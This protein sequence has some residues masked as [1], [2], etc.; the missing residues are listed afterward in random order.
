MAHKYYAVRIGRKPGI[1]D[2]WPECQ[3]QIASYPNARFKSF[4]NRADAVAFVNGANPGSTR[5][6]PPTQ[7]LRND[8]IVM[9]TDGGSRNH[10]NKKGKHVQTTDKAAWAYLIIRPDGTKQ[11]AADGELGATNNRMEIMALLNGLT[12]LDQHGL[13][14]DAIDVVADSKYVLDTITKHWLAGWKRRGWKTSNGQP[15]KNDALWKQVDQLLGRFTD[16]RFHWTKGH[17]D[18]QGNEFVDHQLNKAMDRMGQSGT[19]RIAKPVPERPVTP[20]DENVKKQAL[21]NIDGILNG[22]SAHEDQNKQPD[23]HPAPDHSVST[24]ESVDNIKNSL[25]QLNLF[26]DTDE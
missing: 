25:K 10:G 23:G 15:V 6:A 17:A 19:I 9:Y 4:I 8:A 26:D 5:Q 7:P 22:S 24:N 1:Y 12:Y 21:S 20:A 14:G 18:N 13:N 16:L 3:K 2:S 11:S